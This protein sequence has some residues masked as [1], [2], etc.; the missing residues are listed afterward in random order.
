MI[1]RN[2]QFSFLKKG[3]IGSGSLRCALINGDQ[4]IGK[5]T[6][7][8]NLC[9]YLISNGSHLLISANGRES[10]NSNDLLSQFTR[11][12]LSSDNLD[13]SRSLNEFARNVSGRHRPVC[14]LNDSTGSNDP[15]SA[16]SHFIDELSGILDNPTLSNLKVTPVLIIEDLDS[17]HADQLE[18]LCGE[19]NQALRKSDRFR[20]CRFLF[21][22]TKHIS[23][24]IKFFNDF[25][26]ENP[27]DLK[28]EP[29]TV[30]EINN[31]AESLGFKDVCAQDLAEISKGNPALALNHLQNGFIMNNN[32]KDMEVTTEDTEFDLSKL[33]EKE[34]EFLLY[35]SY[36]AK[37]NRYNLEHFCSPKLAAFTYNWLK[38]TPSV[39]QD[40]PYGDLQ[41]NHS[42]KEQMRAFHLEQEPSKAEEMAT[43]ASVLDAFYDI[44]PDTES[45]WIPIN[46][47]AFNSFSKS[48]CK[49]VFDEFEYEQICLF[50]AN[51]EQVYDKRGKFYCFTDES[52]QLITR[53]ME[54]SG[55]EIKEALIDSVQ[56]VWEKDQIAFQERKTKIESEKNDLN[57]EI[58]DIQSQVSHFQNLKKNI[59]DGFNK[60]K[61]S[62]KSRRVVTFNMSTALVVF[63]LVIVGASLLSDMLGSY[64]AACGLAVTIFGFFWPSVEIKNVNPDGSVSTS[65]LAI[66]TQ[67]R[68]L[69]HRINGLLSRA[70]SIAISLE[71]LGKEQTELEEGSAEPYL[72]TTNTSS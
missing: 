8:E 60:P 45:H 28:L 23:Q 47:Q 20:N 29:L 65:N 14:G 39:C 6:L 30:A 72:T 52:K 32:K 61:Q 70:N 62:I 24:F 19:F 34:L 51:H 11:N 10:N 26:F 55:M 49:K 58:S 66:E 1:G 36:P 9:H 59:E 54:L 71:N 64:H 33:P 16:S 4:G 67:Q 2:K 3:L 38:R 63:G 41:L 12:L 40:L 15:V 50:L 5:T 48:L 13:L 7:L 53:Y 31:L 57:N 22:S 17:L 46:L 42:I 21:S 37:I 25:G 35:A 18:W 68:S 69:E 44:F 43:L 56:G 27:V